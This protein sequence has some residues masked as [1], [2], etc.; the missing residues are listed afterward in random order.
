MSPRTRRGGFWNDLASESEIT[1]SGRRIHRSRSYR[2]ARRDSSR[3][4]WKSRAWKAALA[5]AALGVGYAGYQNR[6]A[7][8]LGYNQGVDALQQ[9]YRTGADAL[10]Q[11]YADARG[12]VGDRIAQYRG[13]PTRA[14][15]LKAQEDIQRAQERQNRRNSWWGQ[16]KRAKRAIVS[17]GNQ[18]MDAAKNYADSRRQEM[19]RVEGAAPVIAPENAYTLGDRWNAVTNVGQNI[20]DTLRNAYTNANVGQNLNDAASAAYTRGKNYLDAQRQNMMRVEANAPVITDQNAYTMGDRWNSLK[21]S[22]PNFSYPNE[23]PLALPPSVVDSVS[24]APLPIYQPGD[25]HYGKTFKIASSVPLNSGLLEVKGN[26]HRDIP[27]KLSHIS[28]AYQP[29]DPHYGKTF[30]MLS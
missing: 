19:E 4:K 12:M 17:S 25:P 9:R 15:I 11:R 18:A 7:L 29:G 2:K 16:T 23:A 24:S 10:Q 22:L 21:N 27:V 8:A 26:T 20:N 13:E 5:A 30:K 6:D 14:E 3:K 28:G 1:Q